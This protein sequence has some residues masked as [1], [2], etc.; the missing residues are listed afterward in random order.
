M[1]NQIKRGRPSNSIKVKKLEE[2]QPSDPSIFY[3]DYVSKD[4]TVNRWYY[5]LNITN[6]GPVMV[7]ID[8]YGLNKHDNSKEDNF[9]VKPVKS[10]VSKTKIK[11]INPSNGKEVGY[12]RAKA[13]GLI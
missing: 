12:T 4:K 7:D 8:I 11:Y 10:K 1:N 6:R 9:E 13:L 3:R 2:I 5:N